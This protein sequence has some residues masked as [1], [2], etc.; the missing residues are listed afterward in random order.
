MLLK[1]SPAAH[2]TELDNLGTLSLFRYP[3]NRTYCIEWKPNERF[4]VAQS[5]AE[6]DDWSFVDTIATRRRTESESLVFNTATSV[7]TAKDQTTN[8]SS[9]SSGDNTIPNNST[10]TSSNSPKLKIIRIKLSDIKFIE[11]QANGNEIKLVKK[12][13][14]KAHSQYFFQQR[15]ADSFLRN[16]LSHQLI[17]QNRKYRNQYETV[18]VRNLDLNRRTFDSLNIDEIKNNR[19]SMTG[20]G[21][22]DILVKFVE[23]IPISPM[24]SE[25]QQSPTSGTGDE[26]EVLDSVKILPEVAAVPSLPCVDGDRPI[27]SRGAPLSEKQWRELLTED[28]R[29]SD[30][31][32]IKEIIYRGVSIFQSF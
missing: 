24:Q 6:Q 26:Y 10:T 12:S 22:T 19:I 11:L 2:I 30:P 31:D 4:M 1:K 5:Q 25:Q 9:S 8:V 32:K 28:G 14:S 7:I 20:N 29:I 21:I 3:V 13:D 23:M 16:M 27:V 18:D 17:K 15:N